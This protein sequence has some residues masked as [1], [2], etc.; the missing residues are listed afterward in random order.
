MSAHAFGQAESESPAAESAE[1]VEVRE[2][3]IV[4]GRQNIIQLQREVEVAQEAFLD[5][6][7]DVNTD[8]LFDFKCEYITRIETGRRRYHVCTPKFAR[9]TVFSSAGSDYLL[10]NAQTSGDPEAFTVKT[11]WPGH[12]Q[13]RLLEQMT[14][15]L[16]DHPELREAYADVAKSKRA[17]EAERQRRRDE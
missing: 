6:F 10:Q 15:A 2:E 3:I 12:L 5:L 11:R 16:R 14:V 1:P 17:L 13:K 8:D 7:N 9:S 4:Y